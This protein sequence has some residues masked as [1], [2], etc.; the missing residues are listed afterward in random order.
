M[1]NK[2]QYRRFI[3]HLH[4]H[5]L[6]RYID[7]PQISVEGDTSS[8]KSSLLTALSGI[9]FPANDKITTR[10]PLRLRMET[11]RTGTGFSAKVG[12]KY[13]ASTTSTTDWPIR[14]LD[15]IEGIPAAVAEAQAFLFQNAGKQIQNDVCFDIIE[16]EVCS[17]DHPDL[18]VID[19]PG[20]VRSTGDGESKNLVRDITSMLKE[21]LSNERCIILAVVPANVD[22]HNSQI[23]ADAEIVDPETRRTI[24]VITK[25][26][27]IDKG[28]EGGVEDLLL[29]K[30][31]TFSM[32][33][34]MVKCRGQQALNSGQSLKESIEAEEI[35]FRDTKPW[36]QLQDR[37]LLGINELREKLAQIQVDLLQKCIPG[38]IDEVD[39]RK[40]RCL[41]RLTALGPYYQTDR[42]RRVYFDNLRN[43]SIRSLVDQLEGRTRTKSQSFC[44]IVHDLNLQFKES[45]FKCPLANV[46]PPL[47][48]G[49]K[50]L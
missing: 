18:T 3:D 5:G 35:F 19:L 17:A 23:M 20:I 50:V 31:K 38:I 39:Q 45:V 41:E 30:I 6:E 2:E 16:I 29:G 48:E 24:P 46:I 33:F 40:A 47:I 25:A 36:S 34:H 4:K 49:L 8:G 32:G 13:H 44:A 15:T 22:F 10:C 27:L 7:L 9:E 21:Y 1:S 14:V 26:D 12:I 42:E 37:S 28:A 43:N 11:C